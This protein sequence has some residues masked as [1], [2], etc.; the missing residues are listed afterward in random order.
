MACFHVVQ[1]G[2]Y[3]AS[4]AQQYGFADWHI[5]YDHP[6]N[7]DFKTMR[8]NPNILLPGDEI[9]I[10]DKEQ[11]QESGATENHHRFQVKSPEKVWLKVVL[12]DAEGE[13]IASQ[14]YT[15]TIAGRALKGT[16]DGTGL[17]QQEIPIGVTSGSLTLDNLGLSWDLRIGHLDPVRDEGSQ[18]AVISGVQ[19]RLNNLGFFCG[20]AD[21]I[22][23]P[24]T[25]NA[26][27]QFQRVVLNREDPT[28]EPDADTQTALMQQHGS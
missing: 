6:Q 21:G 1:Q 9:Y 15:L 4:I 22:L 2:E 3:L 11:K 25:K 13:A 27:M 26:L 24:R 20:E 5:I 10:P 17:V 19:A 8:P 23:G 7:A 14:P 18:E 28:G 12:K 16:T